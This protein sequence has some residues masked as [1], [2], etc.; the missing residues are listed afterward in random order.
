MAEPESRAILIEMAQRWLTLVRQAEINE[1]IE[2]ST[3]RQRAGSPLRLAIFNET[4][5]QRVALVC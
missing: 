5:M 1:K 3:S 4:K 2:L